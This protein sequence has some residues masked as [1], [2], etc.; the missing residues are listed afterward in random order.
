MQTKG[1]QL[2]HI[3]RK[4]AKA[5]ELTG[6]RDMPEGEGGG[7]GARVG[8]EEERTGRGLV[9]ACQNSIGRKHAS[10]LHATW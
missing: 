3:R 9:L 10:S 5:G 6:G 8:M 7:G 1:W 4:G 2:G